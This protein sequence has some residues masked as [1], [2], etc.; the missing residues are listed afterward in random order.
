MGPWVG[1]VQ[2]WGGFRGGAGLAV[3]W[4]RDWA[5]LGAG[6][7]LGAF[8]LLQISTEHCVFLC[9]ALKKNRIHNRMQSKVA[10]GSAF[11]HHRETQK[12]LPSGE[13]KTFLMQRNAESRH[14]A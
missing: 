4:V 6:Q 2:G 11:L 9:I 5:G 7:I 10:K 8:L 14:R 13:K 3:G 12:S 1:Q